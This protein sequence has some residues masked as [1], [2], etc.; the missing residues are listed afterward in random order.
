MLRSP[1][2]LVAF[3]F[4]LTLLAGCGASRQTSAPPAAED[5]NERPPTVL[6]VSLDGFRWD[7]P[8][9]YAT[10]ALDR[11]AQRGVRAEHLLPVFPTKTF[12]NHYTQVTGLYP[13]HHGIVSNTMYDP[14]MDASF[15]LGD[16]AAVRDARWW[17]GEPLWATAEKQGQIAATY[18]WPGSEVAL[19]GVRPTH[20][21]PYDGSVPGAERVDQVLRWLDQPPGRRPTFLTL[22]FSAVDGTGHRFG[23]EAPETAAAV[24]EVDGHLDRLLNGLEARGLRGKIN[25]IIT[26]DHG[27]TATSPRRVIFLDDYLDLESV[28]IVDLSPVAMLRPAPDQADSV[29]AAL[30]DA[31]PHLS[32]YR[33]GTLPERLHFDGHTRIP[34][35]LALADEGWSIATRDL[36]EENPGRFQGGAHGYDPQLASMHGIFYAEG[37]AFAAQP[38]APSFASI[39]LYLL[40]TG[41]LNLTPAPNDG[42][43][44]TAQRIRAS[45][46]VVP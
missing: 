32:V 5:A 40:I 30:E 6:L 22:Y 24:R 34:P 29:Y 31:H 35:L 16:T 8:D 19:G 12:P 15:S 4:L 41:I 43:P 38:A 1:C 20:W 45:Q 37:P 33:K 11:I 7:Y 25:L 14:E 46:P 2:C 13:A 28:Q 42:D 23:P 36:F 10:P 44:A 21:K 17:G 3:F 39:D 26:S 18:F 9:R 27:M